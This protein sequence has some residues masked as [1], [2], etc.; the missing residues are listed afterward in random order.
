MRRAPALV[1]GVVLAVPALLSS[2]VV[3]PGAAAGGAAAGRVSPQAT[4]WAPIPSYAVAARDEPITY[5]NGCHASRPTVVPRACAFAST[6]ATRTIALFGDSHAAHW[7]AAVLASTTRHRWRMLTLT[8][9]GCPATDVR[10]TTYGPAPVYRE[11]PTWRTAAFAALA[12]HRW[13]NVDVVVISNYEF[14]TV[15]SSRDRA[16]TGTAKV[17]AW[18][19]GMRRTLTALLKGAKQVVLLRDSPRLPIASAVAIDCFRRWGQSAQ[20]K[21]GG[22]TRTTLSSAMWAAET[23][24]AASFAGR[25]VVADLTTPTCPRS[26]CGPI[27]GRYLRF[28]DSNHWNQTYM[29]VHFAPLVDALLVPAMSRAVA[30]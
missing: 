21:C 24:A 22:P 10:V 29:R 19:A 7:H 30:G 15:L 1:L 14:Y 25:V 13:R 27:D 20:T 12:A 8:K 3:A 17:S 23:R 4:T 16:L 2:L 28:R 6:T 9:S 5:R 26:W 18:E 11:C